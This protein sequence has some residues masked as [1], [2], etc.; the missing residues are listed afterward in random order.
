MRHSR[1]HKN[2]RLRP[3]YYRGPRW[4]FVTICASERSRPFASK[5]TAEWLI[6]VLRQESSRNLFA[7][8]AY[9]LMP[10]HLHLLL[11]GVSLNANLLQFIARFKQVT[12]H[13]FW[14]R[15]KTDLWQTSFYDHILR[16]EDAPAQV[17]WYIWLNPVRGGLVK[18]PAAYPF[19][20]PFASEL[21]VCAP[22]ESAWEPPQAH[23][24]HGA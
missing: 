5:Q 20:G 10:D 11:N 22:P 9:C 18:F 4:H 23:G 24:K 14:L 6:R 3:E 7:I 16:D 1:W 17:A 21:R 13:R 15:Y 2:I 19:S 8:Q 12:S